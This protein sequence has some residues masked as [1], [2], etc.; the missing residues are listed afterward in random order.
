M[1]NLK[2]AVKLSFPK[3]RITNKP[4]KTVEHILMDKRFKLRQEVK[5]AHDD[6]IKETLE[7]EIDDVEK[8]L[9][10][11]VSKANFEKGK[12]NFS[13]LSNTQGTF[14]VNGMWKA[15]KKSVSQTCKTPTCC[16]SGQ[17]WSFSI[18]T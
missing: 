17:Y 13:V 11:S 5:Q 14:C 15:T 12:E 6:Q 7:K 2:N 18:N 16:Q 10:E 1:K 8:K 4:V 9:S 3:I